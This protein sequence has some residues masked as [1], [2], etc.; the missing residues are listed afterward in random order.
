MSHVTRFFIMDVS[1]RNPQKKKTENLWAHNGSQLGVYLSPSF[2]TRSCKRGEGQATLS[3][4]P[5]R[6]ILSY[7]QEYFPT[8]K[9]TW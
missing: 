4:H 8:S 5:N 6:T 9:S 2:K 3:F 1:E 7:R